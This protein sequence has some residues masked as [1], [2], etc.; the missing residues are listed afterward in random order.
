M[1]IDIA[2]LRELEAAATQGPWEAMGRGIDQ[3]PSPC[4][5]VVSTE[6][7][8]MSYCYGGEAEGITN[9]A[10]VALIVAARN[11]LPEILDALER[12]AEVERIMGQEWL[13]NRGLPPYLGSG[14]TARI[15]AIRKVVQ[16]YSDDTPY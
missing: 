14:D 4:A 16:P 2:R 6:V 10:D 15:S 5:E 3:K 7:R 8:C 13:E 9:E 1:T 12:L 11:A